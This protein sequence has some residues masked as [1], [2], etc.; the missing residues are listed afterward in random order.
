MDE[1]RIEVHCRPAQPSD[2]PDVLELTR[3]IWEGHDY[4]PSIW[5]EWLKDPEGL[6]SVAEYEGQV[7]G[8]GKLTHLAPGQWWLEGLRTNPDFEGRGVAASLHDFLVDYW[9]ESGDGVLRL[10]TASFRLAVQHLCE[11]TGFEKVAE[12]TSFRAPRL[13]G[14]VSSF[15]PVKE[16]EAQKALEFARNSESFSTV[17]SGLINLNWK[18]AA[19]ILE[20]IAAAINRRRA[21]WWRDRE[22]LLL[23]GE[24][25]DDE[26][27]S[28]WT[29]PQILACALM[30][31][32]AFLEDY[33]HLAYDLNV[34]GIEMDAPPRDDMLTRLESAGLG[35]TWDASIYIYARNH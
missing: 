9:V 8:L 4:V 11:R 5:D 19:P 26:E 16:E 24:D 15:Q 22:G 3:R 13:E 23:A 28:E 34:D 18:W 12:F 31:I 33:R 17:S 27:G 21:W 20:N 7:V 35:R 10:A 1:N 25:T 30:D 32:P 6:L 14:P 2:T 29:Y